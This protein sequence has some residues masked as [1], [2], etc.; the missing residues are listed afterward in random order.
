MVTKPIVRG[1]T[2]QFNKGAECIIEKARKLSL[3]YSTSRRGVLPDPAINYELTFLAF[4]ALNHPFYTLL[5][6]RFSL[7]TPI[8]KNLL[9][10]SVM[11][12]KEDAP[13]EENYK[14][15]EIFFKHVEEEA[16]SDTSVLI[17]EEHLLTTVF[18]YR[19][20][21]NY[22]LPLFE[23]QFGIN[24]EHILSFINDIQHS[25]E[26]RKPY[27]P[28]T[29]RQTLYEST[30]RFEPPPLEFFTDSYLNQYGR[31]LNQLSKEG[32]LH[33]IVA[34]E[35]EILA[36]Q[37]ILSRK[38]QNNVILVGYPGVGKTA[39]VEGLANKIARS[40]VHERIKG[41]EIIEISLGS[42]VAGTTLRGEFEE[43]VQKVVKECQKNENIILFFSDIHQMV[44]AGGDGVSSAAN[45]LKPYLL[46]GNLRCIGTTTITDFQRYIERDS[47]FSR[48]FQVV[49]ID[50]PSILLT[51]EIV[52]ELSKKYEEHH[53][54]TIEEEAI[55]A[56][57]ELSNRYIKERYLPGK[58]LSLLDGAASR[59]SLSE[60]SEKKVTKQVIAEIISEIM[61]IPINQILFSKE[62]LFLNL[63][64]KLKQRVFGQD[65]A[66]KRIVDVIQLTKYEMDLKPERPDGVFLIAGPTGTGKTEL[67]KALAEALLGHEK[68]LLRF[69]MSEFIEKHNVAKLIGSPPGYQSSDEGGLLTNVVRANPYSVILFDE[70]EK[71]HPD[72][73]KLFLQIFDDGRL[74]DAK[75]MTVSFSFTTIIMT[76]NLGVRNLNA[77]ELKKIPNHLTQTYI[78]SKMEP[79]IRKFFPPEF[80][81]RLDGILYFNFL[82]QET[83][84]QI[85]KSK[86]ARVLTRFD[87]KGKRLEISEDVYTHILEKGFNLEYGAR[88]LNRTIEDFLLHPITKFVLK[89]PKVKKVKCRISQDKGGVSLK[90]EV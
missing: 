11:R 23:K 76:S 60:S 57:I 46:K 72:V 14:K 21:F 45:L 26:I 89:H 88:F 29:P 75:G 65:A 50:E 78:S 71:A 36:V 44:G 68:E 80:L 56:V 43:R 9:Q 69:D 10:D 66:I 63:E 31:N 8:I 42:L 24:Q 40:Q 52:K 61:E 82:S 7:S 30:K 32:K 4:A 34:R 6:K 48:G 86:I 59:I 22:V 35:K 19:D 25:D 84:K 67:A 38:E 28:Q 74:T 58:A 81:N 79:E 27:L 5:A 41:K 83:V 53:K 15:E 18:K 73:F 51:R 47:S 70:V 33:E 90:C 77:G 64:E 16:K 62:D 49:R 20:S 37:E 87:E 2:A 54:V 85:T 17:C 3:G 13:T 55:D 39:I 12:S 1:I